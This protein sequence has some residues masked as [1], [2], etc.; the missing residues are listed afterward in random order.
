MP[1]P[2]ASPVTLY[3]VEESW[4]S[5]RPTPGTSTTSTTL[6]ITKEDPLVTAR[7]SD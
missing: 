6:Q 1:G 7:G 3:E 4:R 2:V 5:L